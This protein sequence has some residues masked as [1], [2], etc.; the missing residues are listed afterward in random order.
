MADDTGK[1]YGYLKRTDGIC[2]AHTSASDQGTDWREYDPALEPVVEIFQGFAQSYEA[3]GAPRAISDKSDQVHGPFKPAGYVSLA[4]EKG[5]RLGFQSSSDHVATHVSYA[6]V[7]AEELSRKGLIDAIRKRHTYAATDNI[8]LDVRMGTL[9]LMG[10]EV[11][12]A[13]PGLDV[14]ALGT[15]PIDRV[16]VVRNNEVV[17]T[18]R[19]GK[20]EARFHWED[21][22]PVK[23][24]KPSYYYVRVVQRDG[25]MAWSSPIWV[26]V[27]D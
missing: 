27:G 20:E 5:Y 26:T 25:Q 4:L 14:V 21:A 24:A 12:T 19:P 16:E 2:T 17:H 6:C 22:A 8:V 15:G 1:L 11:R 3:P 23:R 18:E 13:K 10:D 7:L 9:G